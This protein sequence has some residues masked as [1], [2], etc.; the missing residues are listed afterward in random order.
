MRRTRRNLALLGGLI[1]LGALIALWSTE[2]A[3][4]STESSL[5]TTPPS[6]TEVDAPSRLA[7]SADAGVHAGVDAGEGAPPRTIKVKV[8]AQ[9]VPLAGATVELFAADDHSIPPCPCPLATPSA[10][11]DGL[12]WM[13]DAPDCDCP[14]ALDALR[15]EAKGSG[16]LSA[17]RGSAITSGDGLAEFPLGAADFANV[18][19]RASGFRTVLRVI[20]SPETATVLNRVRGAAQYVDDL[21][22][23]LMPQAPLTLA[24]IDDDTEATI[25]NAELL[26]FDSVFFAPIAVRHAGDK[27]E[28]VDPVDAPLVLVASAPGY[29]RSVEP[30]DFED[31]VKRPTVSLERSTTVTGRVLEDGKPAEGAQVQVLGSL[32]VVGVTDAH[33]AYRLALPKE[34]RGLV[35]RRGSRVG[36]IVFEDRAPEHVPD[37]VLAS[38]AAVDVL[39]LD[40]ASGAPVEGA[41]IFL[42]DDANDLSATSDPD[43]RASLEGLVDGAF[44]VVAMRREGPGA[45]AQVAPK[46][47]ER[48]SVVLKLPPSLSV[49]G[50]VLTADRKP[51]ADVDVTGRCEDLREV[52]RAAYSTTDAEGRFVLTGLPP[53]TARISASSGRGSA[54]AKARLPTD[55]EVVLTFQAPGS[56]D[57]LVQGPD[58]PVAGALVTIDGV[59]GGLKP[60]DSDGHARADE[61]IPDVYTLRATAPGL[62]QHAFPSTALESGETAHVTI[63]LAALATIRGN[64]VDATGAPMAGV[65][66]VADGDSP[67][68][69]DEGPHAVSDADG[70]F[71][72]SLA[73]AGSYAITASTDEMESNTLQVRTG[74]T[75]VKLVLTSKRHVRGRVVT[76]HGAPVTTFSVDNVEVNAPDGRFNQRATAAAHG[77]SISG[78]FVGRFVPL[79][80]GTGDV[81]LGDVMVGDGATLEGHVIQP[82]GKPAAARV[83]CFNDDDEVSEGVVQVSADDSGTFTLAHLAPGHWSCSGFASRRGGNLL[84]DAELTISPGQARATV[85]LQELTAE[86]AKEVRLD[87][88][89]PDDP[90]TPP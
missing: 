74:D 5:P 70:K 52:S 41:E 89:A 67:E 78:P 40:A 73:A 75:H 47:G 48:V 26:V 51:A 34:A 37:I 77:I 44:E 88:L 1:A 8:L 82:N 62:V 45:S 84:R 22:L 76:A 42:R 25:R 49:H 71:E 87:D 86:E 66:V 33:G 31:L 36:S 35:A 68:W 32:G 55:E 24:V 46:P 27:L 18:R 90:N 13:L 39:V 28:L 16:H 85:Q 69:T 4:P 58:G 72:L 23:E 83:H 63:T 10:P 7:L 3:E 19:V 17:L 57:V 80:A 61:L 59:D 29:A 30:S 6:T 65:A 53:G 81:E 15:A 21:T 14:A 56:I 54:E 60:T 20:L 64:T 43:G 9:H 11:H 38:A 50:R 12:T 2:R 79:P